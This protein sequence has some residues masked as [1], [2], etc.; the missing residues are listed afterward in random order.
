MIR[1]L[2]M[3][4]GL[5]SIAQIL[6]AI[7]SFTRYLT[8]NLIVLSEDDYKMILIVQTFLHC[9]VRWKQNE[10]RYGK[11]GPIKETLDRTEGRTLKRTLDKKA[12]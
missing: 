3:A 2:T 4:P 8:D 9:T 10:A 11:I 12:V 7:F 5:S 1:K 6:R